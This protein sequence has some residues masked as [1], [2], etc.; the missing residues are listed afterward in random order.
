MSDFDAD[1]DTMG[2]GD[3]I[4]DE[5]DEASHI[6]SQIANHSTSSRHTH[7]QSQE[8][9][10]QGCCDCTDCGGANNT[11]VCFFEGLQRT[12][13]SSTTFI[14]TNDTS[15]LSAYYTARDTLSEF[16]DDGDEDANDGGDG[17]RGLRSN[18]NGFN[19]DG[20]DPGLSS[21]MFTKSTAAIAAA[22][23][24]SSSPSPKAASSSPV[25]PHAVA[26]SNSSMSPTKAFLK[27]GSSPPHRRTNS[28]TGT[29][30]TATS[31][32]QPATSNQQPATS[33]QQPTTNNRQQKITTNW[34]E[35]LS[36]IWFNHLTMAGEIC[37]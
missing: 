16:D 2:F 25:L 11:S 26:H 24:S 10:Y 15:S 12:Y 33:N 4:D 35:H 14:S 32:Q 21:H 22:S 19:S 27:V 5:E 9:V 29:S 7:P 8:E 37:S 13:S 17:G 1:S 36:K 28:S 31:N 23:A 6:A 18:D 30:P 34:F 20:D 3:A